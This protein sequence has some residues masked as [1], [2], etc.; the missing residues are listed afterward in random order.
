MR[1]LPPLAGGAT[2][3][4]SKSPPPVGSPGV[5][6]PPRARSRRGAP[7]LQFERSMPLSSPTLPVCAL[8]AIL[9]LGGI[10]SPQTVY[11]TGTTI[12][13]ERADEGLT[14]FSPPSGGVVLID[15]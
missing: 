12:H 3:R 4:G 5:P 9:L 7:S 1:P 15:M 13:Y 11:P 2:G 10:A 8:P 6:R 14:L